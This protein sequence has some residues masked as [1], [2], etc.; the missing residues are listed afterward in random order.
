MVE[1]ALRVKGIYGVRTDRKMV[2]GTNRD[3]GATALCSA[4][5]IVMDRRKGRSSWFVVD[6]GRG[7]CGELSYP[8]GLRGIKLQAWGSYEDDA[9]KR[10]P[11]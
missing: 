9:L 3:A 10:F 5:G 6:K 4:M 7:K 1:A 11:W 2:L 8:S